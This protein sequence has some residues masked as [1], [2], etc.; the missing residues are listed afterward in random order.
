MATTL[1]RLVQVFREVLDDEDLSFEADSQDP[2]EGWDSLAHVQLMLGIESE[3]DVMLTT[4][5]AAHMTSI[6]AILEVLQAR[7][8]AG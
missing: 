6:P 8:V 3:F 7:G 2:I 1:Y 5:D 4:E